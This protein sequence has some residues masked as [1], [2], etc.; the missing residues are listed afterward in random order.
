VQHGAPDYSPTLPV[1]RKGVARIDNDFENAERVG[2]TV[3]AFAVR[4]A[5]RTVLR[6]SGDEL[7]TAFPLRLSGPVNAS[8][9]WWT[10][11]P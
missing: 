3:V 1:R 5:G 10:V 7:M 6:G 8:S 11:R 4:E 2:T 9:N